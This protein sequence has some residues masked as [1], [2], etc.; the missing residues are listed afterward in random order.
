MRALD[1]GVRI[2]SRRC[3]SAT[4]AFR[5]DTK[6]GG[7]KAVLSLRAYIAFSQL[8]APGGSV[9]RSLPLPPGRLQPPRLHAKAPRSLPLRGA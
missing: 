7:P 2:A 5:F 6:R 9:T 3:D 8:I 4:R 1:G